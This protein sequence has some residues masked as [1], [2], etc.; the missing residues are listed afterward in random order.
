MNKTSRLWWRLVFQPNSL[1]RGVQIVWT[2]VHSISSIIEVSM[3]DLISS[4]F[5]TSQAENQNW[6]KFI[7]MITI[8]N[9]IHLVCQS[10][11]GDGCPSPGFH[12][13]LLPETFFCTS[14]Y[15]YFAR[16]YIFTFMHICQ[17]AFIHKRQLISK[18]LS[19]IYASSHSRRK[20][21]IRYGIGFEIFIVNRKYIWNSE[22]IVF[23]S[24]ATFHFYKTFHF[25]PYQLIPAF[26]ESS[27]V[28][29]ILR[30]DI[31]MNNFS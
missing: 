11:S 13:G 21:G 30:T 12:F 26:S 1:Q 19:T 22:H 9:K 17:I 16:R 10:S 7:Y 8:S 28:W 20:K 23:S 5:T 31:V 29:G 24:I 14:A 2:G 18:F 27:D 25:E 4:P 15:L 3:W 6:P